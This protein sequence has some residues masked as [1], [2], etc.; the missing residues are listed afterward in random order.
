M[1]D[2][3]VKPSRESF[4]TTEIPPRPI[5]QIAAEAAA[6]VEV[7]IQRLTQWGVK[8]DRDSRLHKALTVLRHAIAT[9]ALAPQHRGDQLGLRSLEIAFDYG[10]IARTLPEKSVA[11]IRREIGDSLKGE[12]EPPE[13]ARGPVQLQSQGIARAAFVMAGLAPTHPTHSPKLGRSSPDL[14][15]ENG[16]GR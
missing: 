6:D 9:G 14:M 1:K 11:A 3:V 7:S 15:L 8:V 16:L 13:N 10:A 2:D 12:I 5:R 4:C